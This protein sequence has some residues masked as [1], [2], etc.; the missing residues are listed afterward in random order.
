MEGEVEKLYEVFTDIQEQLGVVPHLVI[1][2]VTDGI[3]VSVRW[4][5]EGGNNF[6]IGR[7]VS[8]GDFSRNAVCQVF[9]PICDD[10]QDLLYHVNRERSEVF[11]DELMSGA[12][13]AELP[14]I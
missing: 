14:C 11:F 3:E 5:D 13:P 7:M 8:E 2:P 1:K 4:K 12:V 6:K 10:I 9:S